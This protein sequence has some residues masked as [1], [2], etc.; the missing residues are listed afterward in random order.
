MIPKSSLHSY[1][2][3]IQEFKLHWSGTSFD[4]LSRAPR[5]VCCSW[6]CRVDLYHVVSYDFQLQEDQIAVNFVISHS[7]LR[8]CYGLELFYAGL[9]IIVL[10]SVL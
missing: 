4:R 6:R 10:I 2:N 5:F 3:L 7:A 8:N 9:N 1:A